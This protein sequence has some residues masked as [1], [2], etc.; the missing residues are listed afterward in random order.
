MMHVLSAA[1]QK[2]LSDAIYKNLVFLVVC[3]DLYYLQVCNAYNCILL[4]CVFFSN[5]AYCFIVP[6]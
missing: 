1:N 6:S 2:T 5:N 4:L 3:L